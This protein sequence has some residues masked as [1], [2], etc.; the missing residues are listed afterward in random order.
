MAYFNLIGPRAV[1]EDQYQKYEG[2]YDCQSRI[3]NAYDIEARMICCYYRFLTYL[4]TLPAFN[5]KISHGQTMELITT[6]QG[7]W[8]APRRVR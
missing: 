6:E 1:T 4:H 2:G 5:K 8:R 3:L 7:H